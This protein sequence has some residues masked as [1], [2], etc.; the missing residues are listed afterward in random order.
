MPTPGGKLK[1]G[2]RLMHDSEPGTVWVVR[3]R[4][5]NDIAYAV[6]VEREDGKELPPTPHRKGDRKSLL[7]LEA[8]Y[9]VFM[10]HDGWRLCR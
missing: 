4:T 8:H 2:D 7:L 3:E 10:A 6:V 5:G 9:W 1:A